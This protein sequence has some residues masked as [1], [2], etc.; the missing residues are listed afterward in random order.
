MVESSVR[1]VSRPVID[2]LPLDVAQLDDFACRQ[3]D[4]FEWS[5]SSSTPPPPPHP[6][7][8]PPP[9]PQTQITQRS[10][11]QAVLLEAGGLSAA[12]SEESMRR[13]KYCLH[14][15]QYATAHIDAQILI[16]RDFTATLQPLPP[17]ISNSTPS[18]PTDSTTNDLDTDPISP[19]HMRTL[20]DVRRDVVT[21]IRQV[22]DVV[23]KYAGSALPEPARTRVRGFILKLPQKWAN[24]AGTSTTA[25]TST[26]ST[27]AT[28]TTGA[29]RRYQ[30]R[31]ERSSSATS[32]PLS[33]P[34]IGLA[35]SQS[36]L[37]Y[38]TSIATGSMGPPPTLTPTPTTGAAVQAAQRILALATE[39]LDMMR[40]VT[41][42]VKDSLD[43]ADAWVGR[44][45]SVGVG[46][47]VEGQDIDAG[48]IADREMEGQE[49]E[50]RER[51]G[52]EGGEGGEGREE[53]SGG[54]SRRSYSYY[55][56]SSTLS[57]VPSTPGPPSPGARG[58]GGAGFSVGG[59][60]GFGI[61]GLHLGK[62]KDGD[63]EG[64]GDVA[65][66]GGGGGGKEVRAERERSEEEEG[67]EGEGDR[68]DVDMDADV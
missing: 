65:G 32:S 51:E 50:G 61:G 31:R 12:L 62:E 33:S 68:M 34:R 3:L 14:W 38:P 47:P 2:H 66:G 23:S 64:D 44:L 26:T 41:G 20:T 19:A 24:A 5:A 8:P 16:L 11:W 37:P 48:D 63:V 1:A 67:E 58:Q 28:T 6:P 57:S 22:V 53:E 56:T 36:Q 18:T 40:G 17:R 4:R 30:H 45:R 9:H 43:R 49:G 39:S 13:L 46:G 27:T 60:M 59:A 55:S 42:V 54:L 25:T 7:P 29:K 10:R 21:T 52:G 35:R 15:L